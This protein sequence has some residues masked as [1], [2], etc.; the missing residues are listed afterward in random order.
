[1]LAL[2][3]GTD[4]SPLLETYQRL[5][6]SNLWDA[7]KGFGWVGSKPQSRDR[8][9]RFDP[10]RRDFTNDTTAR[11]LRVSVPAGPHEAFILVGDNNQCYPTYVKSGGEL[12]AESA[13]LQNGVFTWIRFPLDGGAAGRDVDLEL[14]SVPGQHWHVNAFVL[15]AASS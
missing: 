3:S 15:L 6:P 7:A 1:V 11:T 9:S 13:F 12:L 4:T 2:D 10:L 5:S 14:S 8:G